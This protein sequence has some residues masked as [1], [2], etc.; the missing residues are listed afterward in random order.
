MDEETKHRKK[1][2]SSVSKSESR[3]NHK[4]IY[5]PCIIKFILYNWGERCTVCGRTRFDWS[6]SGKDLQRD[7][8]VRRSSIGLNDFL[9]VQEMKQKFPGVKIY[10]EYFENRDIKYK[11]L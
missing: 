4:H 6:R 2:P 7:E 3:S 5:E 9:T 11:E 8:R 10:E 1:K